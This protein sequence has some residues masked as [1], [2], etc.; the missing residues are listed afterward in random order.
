[1]NEW[2]YLRSLHPELPPTPNGQGGQAEWTQ[3]EHGGWVGPRTELHFTAAVTRG[4]YV[5]M[6]YVG[7]NTIIERNSYVECSCLGCSISVKHSAI[8]NCYIAAFRSRYYQANLAGLIIHNADRIA[9]GTIRPVAKDKIRWG[10][11]HLTAPICTVDFQELRRSTSCLY[12][13]FESDYAIWHNGGGRVDAKSIIDN[14]TAI[15]PESFVAKGQVVNSLL[16]R[17]AFVMGNALV[18]TCDIKETSFTTGSSAANCILHNSIISGSFLR[19]IHAYKAH[20]AAA[21]IEAAGPM[22]IGFTQYSRLNAKP[23]TSGESI[24]MTS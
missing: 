2:N 15:H 13:A 18:E 5:Y 21:E 10:L 24:C 4:S 20:I 7:D 6:S 1:M 8:R 17:R 14:L 3:T 12:G 23:L 9:A 22:H 19:N 16:D 11:N